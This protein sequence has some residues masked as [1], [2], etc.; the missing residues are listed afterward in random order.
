[1]EVRTFL[2][3]GTTHTQ[4]EDACLGRTLPDGR[5]LLVGSDGCSGSEGSHLGSEALCS[6]TM[7]SATNNTHQS[8]LQRGDGGNPVRVI[9]RDV[10]NRASLAMKMEEHSADALHATLI[11]AYGSDTMGWWVRIFGDGGLVIR[12]A[13]GREVAYNFSWGSA[14]LY[15]VYHLV[16]LQGLVKLRAEKRKGPV[17]VFS[18]WRESADTSWQNRPLKK[19]PTTD[20]VWG[21]SLYI[22]PSME[23][24]ALAITSDGIAEM[25][26]RYFLG[27]EDVLNFLA[28]G[29]ESV[30][31]KS[32]DDLFISGFIR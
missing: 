13:D 1:M 7:E 22:P 27:M 19:T 23:V 4:C 24:A 16:G 20:A 32:E 21:H 30:V 6:W 18:C 3:Q 12:Y 28:T 15:P 31:P 10:L 8:L 9:E 5:V 2:R 14:P 11:T 25:G 17:K 26:K 29:D